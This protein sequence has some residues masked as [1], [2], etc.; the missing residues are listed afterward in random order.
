MVEGTHRKDRHGNMDNIAKGQG[1]FPDIPPTHLTPEQ[2]DA[3]K[4]VVKRIPE[5]ILTNSDTI[6]VEIIACLLA[7]YRLDPVG[8]NSA[9]ITRLTVEMGKLGLNPSDRSK[10]GITTEENNDLDGWEYFK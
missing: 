8:M 3:W 4:E 1:D 5:G 10:L 9:R 6:H 2:A 7:E